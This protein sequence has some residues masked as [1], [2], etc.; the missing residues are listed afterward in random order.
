MAKVEIVDSYV[1]KALRFDLLKAT[2]DC[3]AHPSISITAPNGTIIL[4]GGA[5][6]DWDG[7][8]ADSP[9][10]IGNLITGM[11]PSDD[12]TTWTVSGKDHIQS[13]PASIAAYC[14]VARKTDGTPIP[15]E[16]YT[17]VSATSA[18]AAH[19]TLQVNLPA[20]FSVVGGGA[21]ANYTGAGSMLYASNPTPKLDGWVGSAKDHIQSDPAS[22]T[23]W[24]IGLKQQFLTANSM[25][26]DLIVATKTTPVGAHHPRVTVVVPD[27]HLTGGG[28]VVNWNG[29]GSLLTAS[30]PQ[31]RQTWIAEGKDHI[32]SD[33]STITGYAIGFKTSG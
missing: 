8:C 3:A 16:Y 26:G 17:I 7:P 10:P 22:I 25:L 33:I 18:V 1:Y 11:F 2:S 21:R 20:G 32:D 4:G 19:P 27:F 28:A 13:S 30:F 9:T 6:D 5:F 23:V 24:A 14:I 29:A 15:K 31:D 12:G